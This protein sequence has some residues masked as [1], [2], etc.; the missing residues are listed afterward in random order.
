MVDPLY[1]V[2]V[3]LGLGF[4]LPALDRT[5]KYITVFIFFAGLIS[6]SAIGYQ[7]L[8]EFLFNEQTTALFFTAGTKPPMSINFRMGLEEAIMVATVNI[9]SLIGAVYMLDQLTRTGT[10][11]FV[12]YLLMVL[13]LNGLI[14]TGDIFNMFVF[15]EITAISTYSIIGMDLEKDSL[16]AGFKYMIAGGIASVF[17]LLGIIMIYSTTGTLSL[18]QI[19]NSIGGLS[20]AK[21]ITSG[22][23]FIIFSFIIELKQFPVN[24]WA[25]DVYEGVKPGFTGLNASVGAGAVFYAFYKILPMMTKPFLLTVF[26]IGIITFILSNLM[27]LKQENPRRMLGYSSV[28]QIGL[29]MMVSS[30]G[31]I[32][33]RNTEVFYMMFL[34]LFLNHFFAKAGLF[35]IA[36]IVKKNDYR[37][38]SVLR[39][40]RMITGIFIVFTLALIGLPPFPG[41]WGKW[42]LIMQFGKNGLHI[43]IWLILLG[44]LLEAGFMLRWLGYVLNTE[45]DQG[46]IEYN[47]FKFLAVQLTYIIVIILSFYYLFELS[48]TNMKFYLPFSAGIFLLIFWFLPEK[49]KGVISYAAVLAYGYYFIPLQTGY[50]L[51]FNLMFL[52]GT[53]FL[54][55]GTFAVKRSK[56]GFYGYLM[57]M[58]G[59]LIAIVNAEGM[60]QFFIAWEIMTLSSYLLITRGKRS[61]KASYNYIMFSLAGAFL[62]LAGFSYAYK[63]YDTLGLLAMNGKYQALIFI[64]LTLGFLVKSAAFG[65][66][67]WIGKTYARSEDEVTP[68]L[69]ALLSK[70][71]VYGLVIV[72]L[73]MGIPKAGKLDISVILG[74]IGA[75]T[76]V[77][78]TMIAIYQEDAKKLLAYSSMGQVGYIFM[79]LA[80]MTGLGWTAAMYQ[81]INH[82]LI[83]SIL[84]LAI[85]GVIQRTGTSKMYKMGGLLKRMPWS[86]TAVMFAIIALSG[87]PPLTGFGAKWLLYSALIDKGWYLQAGMAFFAS[88]VA[89]LYLFRLIHT[90]FLGQP[91]YEFI[92]VKKASAWFVVPQYLMIGIIMLFS[93]R[94]K[95]LLDRITV[96]IE[97]I[98]GKSISWEGNTAV[99]S[100]G[101][102]DAAMIM[103]VVGVIFVVLLAVLLIK[104][105]KVQKVKQFNI[106]FAG[107]RPETPE[108]THFAYEFYKPYKRA[109]GWMV[110]PRAKRFWSGVS[111]WTHT[112]GDTL[113]KIYSGNAQTYVYYILLTSVVL[114][115]ITIGVD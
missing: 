33:G 49:I 109:L 70:A 106:V 38:W 24:G 32:T 3:L 108:L 67:I 15:L 12:L 105:P 102:W 62:I 13:G 22:L 113:R 110:V 103:N 107:E 93:M 16:S 85:A 84:F 73:I 23:F 78:G 86:F 100:F 99:N 115:F 36:G 19:N 5:G 88:T 40:N 79:G 9:T 50:R 30:Y 114:F 48:G 58:I 96:M 29:L 10:K 111:E 63:G 14:L 91:K 60:L 82:F 61:M 66:H 104:S 45:K 37:K 68:F 26:F 44:S 57:L 94:P 53:L 52:S 41:F 112:L 81:M 42:N 77:T 101:Y 28:A 18:V 20:S 34:P 80:V 71:G 43:Y 21:I 46:I 74:W 56:S 72:I 17:L 98:L 54:L 90:I 11:A 76:A 1:I 97:P 69:S 64:L 65:V 92:N 6:V 8:W 4:L 83:K 39:S 31:F 25:L 2:A 27:G 89:F 7:W 59:A 75:L 35:W 47:S 95:L 55:S 51:F 87:V